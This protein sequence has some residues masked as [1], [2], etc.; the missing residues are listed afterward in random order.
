MTEYIMA[1]LATGNLDAKN[2]LQQH[3]TS[4]LE[5][6]VRINIDA[7]LPLDEIPGRA[8]T[9]ATAA[10]ICSVQKSLLE[11]PTSDGHLISHDIDFRQAV[12]SKT[13]NTMIGVQWLRLRS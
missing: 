6:Y 3:E 4:G 11:A 9:G 7:S 2:G 10:R 5:H 13:S 1:G 12:C 8:R